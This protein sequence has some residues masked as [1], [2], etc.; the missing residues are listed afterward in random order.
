MVG[1]RV[2]S[3]VLVWYWNAPAVAA[4]DGINVPVVNMVGFSDL[5]KGVACSALAVVGDGVP[6]PIPPMPP[7]IPGPLGACVG[8][9]VVDKA[10][11]L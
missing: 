6:C 7:P 2:S 5:D 10:P 3:G 8:E 11:A 4:V 1:E 9:C